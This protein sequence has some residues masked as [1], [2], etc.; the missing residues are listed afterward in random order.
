[1]LSDTA[2]ERPREDGAIRAARID[3]IAIALG[4]KFDDAAATLLP[5]IRRIEDVATLEAIMAAIGPAA[6]AADVRAVY[7][8]AD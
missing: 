1:M 6:T 2:P 8:R 3:G 4:L 5:E 7:A